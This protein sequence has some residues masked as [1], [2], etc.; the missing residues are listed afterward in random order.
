MGGGRE[1]AA[2]YNPLNPTPGSISDKIIVTFEFVDE[3]LKCDFQV[4]AI[5]G[6]ISL[7]EMFRCE[8]IAV[9]FYELCCMLTSP[10]GESKY[11]QGVKMYGNTLHQNI[12]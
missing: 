9:N 8:V 4:R 3:I 10:Q 12:F 7:T 11:K 1:I 5:E 2:D 6:Y